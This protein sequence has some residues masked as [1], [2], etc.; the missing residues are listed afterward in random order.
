[1]FRY[2][3]FSTSFLLMMVMGTNLSNAQRIRPAV[4]AVETQTTSEGTNFILHL[5]K[6]L[7]LNVDEEGG[8]FTIHLPDDVKWSPSNKSVLSSPHISAYHREGNNIVVDMKPKVKIKKVYREVNPSQPNIASQVIQTAEEKRIQEATQGIERLPTKKPKKSYKR[9]KAEIKSP[10]VYILAQKDK[11]YLI[12]KSPSIEVTSLENEAHSL[13]ITLKKTDWQQ[14]DLFQKSGGPIRNVI[15]HQ[16]KETVLNILFSTN[17]VA[18][19]EH[20][21]SNPD[22]TIFV[23]TR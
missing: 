4:H 1:M 8:K 13:K 7:N 2:C 21:S 22:E 6:H 23:F 18:M 12:L 19:N 14:N 9:E 3:C 15:L 20:P 17:D 11:T 16:E 5:D 10:G